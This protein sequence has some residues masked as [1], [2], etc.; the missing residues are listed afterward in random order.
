MRIA[1]SAQGES[2][3]IPMLLAP[4]QVATSYA[5]PAS[6]TAEDIAL[7]QAWRRII[8]TASTRA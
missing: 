2:A 5:L 4:D 7:Y 6:G 3:M 8:Q 1:A